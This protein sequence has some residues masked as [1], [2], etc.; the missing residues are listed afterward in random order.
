MSDSDIRQ[1]SLTQGPIFKALLA[2]SLPM[3]LTNTV[4]ILFHAADVGVLAIF[5]SGP[6]VAA[7]GACGSLISLL[8]SIFTGLATG[9]NVLI[10][11]TIGANDEQ[12]TK[13]AIG[14][15]LTVGLLS[16]IILMIIAL[17]FARQF[18]IMMNCQPD[19]LDMATLYLQ[20]YFLGMPIMML[21]NFVIAILRASGDSLRPMIYM[22]I[23]GVV[24]VGANIFFVT[25]FNMTVDGVALATVLSTAIALV[26]ALI[27]LLRETGI[28]RIELKNLRIHKDELY[29]ITRIGVPTCFCSIFFYIGGVVI[30]SAVN[31]MSTVA[32]TANAI[33]AQFDGIIYTV[34]LAIAMSTSVMVAQ[35]YGAGQ[36]ARIKKIL[37]V[38]VVYTTVTSLSLGAIF[39]LFSDL[40]LGIMSDAPEVLAMAKER[41]TLLCL[42]YFL[43][44][45]MEVMALSLRVLNKPKA[46]VLV[47]F[48]CGLVFRSLWVYFIWP[49]N[50]TL[51]MLY[52]S[53]ALSTLL[54]IGIY[55]LF[56]RSAFKSFPKESLATYK[57]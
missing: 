33:S 24:N 23:S 19:V 25:V 31:S 21:N 52:S 40:L 27:R 10:S 8:V 30:S 38:S 34:G 50:P 15:S 36:F 22:I 29:D 54:A 43:T 46:T 44:S 42:T 1:R 57:C 17:I 11:K 12:R 39:V 41:M 48:V 16:G 9:A 55:T 5:A 4:N 18:L 20:I 6:A 3:I 14:T 45:I 28:C 26:L 13:K 35:N 7:V 32:M 53:F 56:Y 2:F 47:G 49:M 37:N 51:F